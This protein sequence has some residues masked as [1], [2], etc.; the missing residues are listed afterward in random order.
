MAAQVIPIVLNPG[1]AVVTNPSGPVVV[2]RR[3]EGDW[4]ADVE[5]VPIPAFD[6]GVFI[7]ELTNEKLLPKKLPELTAEERS[8]V[9]DNPEV[10]LEKARLAENR[11]KPL[12]EGTY[13]GTQLAITKVYE[14][15]E[16]K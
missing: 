13:R 14:L 7:A 8:A 6:T 2:R 4:P 11:P 3:T 5:K 15:I 10:L 12:K 16:R 1:S 9:D